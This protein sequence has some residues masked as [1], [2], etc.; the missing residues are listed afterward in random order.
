MT[1]YLGTGQVAKRG[2]PR[3]FVYQLARL[4]LVPGL[5]RIN[6]TVGWSEESVEA[7]RKLFEQAQQPGPATT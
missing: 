3:D 5:V 1:R 4:N 2:L 6:R 7:A